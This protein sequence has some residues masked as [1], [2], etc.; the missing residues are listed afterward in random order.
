MRKLILK[1]TSLFFAAAILIAGCK[2]ASYDTKLSVSSSDS[3]VSPKLLVKSKASSTKNAVSLPLS[4]HGK[5]KFDMI[6][7][8]DF[9]PSTTGQTAFPECFNAFDAQVELA[10]ATCLKPLGK[11]VPVLAKH[12]FQDCYTKTGFSRIIPTAEFLMPD[13]SKARLIPHTFDPE[14]RIDVE[15]SE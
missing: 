10:L 1:N 12:V 3:M 15:I 13:C 14:V 2:A 11:S 6:V 5:P 4:D 8:L 7:S 9:F